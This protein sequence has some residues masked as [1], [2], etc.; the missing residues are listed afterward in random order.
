MRPQHRMRRCFFRI[1]VL[2]SEALAKVTVPT[3]VEKW[4]SRS[5]QHV[6]WAAARLQ[7]YY[8]TSSRSR[9][10][11]VADLKKMPFSCILLQ[12]PVTLA[13]MWVS[14]K[15][16][17]VDRSSLKKAVWGGVPLG[18][19]QVWGISDREHLCHPKKLRLTLWRCSNPV[20]AFSGH[21]W[22]RCF[23]IY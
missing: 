17:S 23:P 9:V 2:L 1:A 13:G 15:A 10:P 7:E 4:V 6:A 14:S 19:T 3:G 20:N 18:I 21:I 8:D 11:S 16:D 22:I 12:I 5:V